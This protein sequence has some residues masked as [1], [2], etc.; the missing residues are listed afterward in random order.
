MR[1]Y[2]LWLAL[3]TI[4][5]SSCEVTVKKDD[6]KEST[7]GNSKIKNSII[8]TSTNIKVEQAF[9]LFEDGKLV[10]ADNTVSVDQKVRLRLIVSGWA[11]KEG[12]SFLSAAEKVETS[13]G[14]T[15]LNEDNL[16]AA[17]T[18]G[19]DA[20]DAQYISLDVVI[21]R[22]SKLYDYY[23]VNFKVKDN[24]KADNVVEGHYKLYIK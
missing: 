22:V 18:N 19:I 6:G 7:S 12:K 20:K 8:V 15:V 3:I 10:P 9:L 21:T 2:F 17:Y 4:S 16:F 24:L 23:L 14:D 13:E 1:S 5:L 11:E